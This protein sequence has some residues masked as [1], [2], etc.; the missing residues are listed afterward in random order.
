VPLTRAIASQLSRPGVDVLPLPRPPVD[1]LKAGHVG[2]MAQLEAALN[3]FVSDA[4]RSFRSISGDPAAIITSHDDNEI[5]VSLSSPF[6][7]TTV[8]G[9]RWPLHPLD[10]IESISGVIAELLVECRVSDVRV[11]N[12][13]LPALNV[14]GQ[15]FVTARDLDG[16]CQPAAH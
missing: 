2:R 13:V 7:D 1:F 15:L 8:E 3:L 9:F 16:E 4:V 6:D 5:R 11:L 14:R 10:D 12:K